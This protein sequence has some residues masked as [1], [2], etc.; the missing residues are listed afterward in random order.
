MVNNAIVEAI[1]LSMNPLKQVNFLSIILKDRILTLKIKQRDYKEKSREESLQPN[2][3]FDNK[4]YTLVCAKTKSEKGGMKWASE[5]LTLT[6]VAERGRGIST[7]NLKEIL[8]SWGDFEGLET[9]KATARMNLFQSTLR[10]NKTLS[11]AHD[12]EIIEEECNVGC[13]FIPEQFIDKW[14]PRQPKVALQVRVFCPRLGIFKGVLMRK[15]G[16]NCIQLPYSMKKVERATFGPQQFS[17]EACVVICKAFPTN[18]NAQLGNFFKTGEQPTESFEREIKVLSAMIRRM[19]S[20]LGVPKELAD[21]YIKDAKRSRYLKHAWLCGVVDPTGGIPEG[22]VFITGLGLRKQEVTQVFI[23]RSP[24]MEASDAKVLPNI[25]TKPDEISSADWKFLQGL[26]FGA[27]I[28]GNPS[29]CEEMTLPESIAGGDLDG[30]L[31]FICWNKCIVKNTFENNKTRISHILD[32]WKVDHNEVMLRVDLFTGERIECL[33]SQIMDKKGAGVALGRFIDQYP[34]KTCIKA[35]QTLLQTMKSRDGIPQPLVKRTSLV[36][37]RILEHR[38]VRN[39]VELKVMI[40][41]IGVKFEPLEYV[42]DVCPDQVIRYV[43]AKH[44]RRDPHFHTVLKCMKDE[45][46]LGSRVER[47][48]CAVQRGREATHVESLVTI[49]KDWFEKA[50]DQMLDMARRDNISK[51]VKYLY[52]QCM[53]ESELIGEVFDPTLNRTRKLR[54]FEKEYNIDQSNAMAFGRAFKESLDIAKHNT[55]V[56]LPKE[57]KSR[58]S[59]LFWPMCNWV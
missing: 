23:T 5:T 21:N 46:I 29:R 2:F 44:L 37:E 52:N 4:W 41:G 49:E 56:S 53:K 10:W 22:H 3:K 19:W 25:T 8:Q 13:G 14:F 40:R 51:F 30:D 28:F 1:H 18:V 42:L 7:V 47:R 45:S 12:F 55:K 17:D 26:P 35:L 32:G 24:C 20:G 31:Y 11:S 38:I 15:P 34:T 59:E 6:Y 50:Q 9:N 39:V 16:I 43:K 36:L 58:V 57:L 27:I 48:R 33:G 54:H